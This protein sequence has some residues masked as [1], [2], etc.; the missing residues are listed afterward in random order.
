M[1]EKYS[2]AMFM[3]KGFRAEQLPNPGKLSQATV[4]LQALAIE[5]KRNFWGIFN[6]AAIYLAGK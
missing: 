2:S 4:N 6:S 3:G 5:K 1:A